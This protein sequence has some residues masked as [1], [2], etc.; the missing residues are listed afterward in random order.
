MQLR[1]GPLRALREVTWTLPSWEPVHSFTEKCQAYS[2]KGPKWTPP[3]LHGG[4]LKALRGVA[5]EHAPPLD[6][7]STTDPRERALAHDILCARRSPPCLARRPAADL[8][9]PLHPGRDRPSPSPGRP[10]A[11]AP[12]RGAAGPAG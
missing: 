6:S 10:S 5:E 4:S 2:P 11:G 7:C 8:P 3:E 1:R 9:T 12:R